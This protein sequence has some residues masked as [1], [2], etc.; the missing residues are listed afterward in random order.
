MEIRKLKPEENVHRILM[1]SICFTA[2][3]PADRYAWLAKPEDH[4]HGHEDAWGAFDE[5][6]RLL[7]SMVLT[8]AQIM[9]NGWPVKAVLVGSVITLPEARNARCVRKIFE[10]IMPLMAEEGYVYSILYPFS[11]PF[12]RKFGYEHGLT[13]MRA[14]FPTDELSKYPYPNGIK[15]HDKGGPWAD[16]ATV[17]NVFA[18]D[19]NIA[20]V[21]GEKEW[22][23]ILSRDPHQNREFSYLHYNLSGES[24]GYVLYDGNKTERTTMDIKELAWANKEGLYAILGF[25]HGLRSEYYNISWI[26]PDGLDIFGVVESSWNVEFKVDSIV[27]NRVMDVHGALILLDTPLGEGSVVVGVKDEFLPLNSGAYHVSWKDSRL[28]VEKTTQPPDIDMDV[29]TLSQLTTGYLTP[30]EAQFRPDVSLHGKLVE[31]TALFPK[32]NLYLM[33]FF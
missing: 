30:Y 22:K 16:F 8:K 14:T 3:G 25:I 33:E 24:D 17:Y 26:V 1:S 7:S 12:Y 21:R 32:K 18:K 23:G 10:V 20:M 4:T 6:G 5:N 13:K 19:K 15:V 29:E 2:T 28:R 31:L 9:I 11:F 27:M